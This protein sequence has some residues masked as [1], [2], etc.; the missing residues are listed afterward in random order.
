MTEVKL[1]GSLKPA[2]PTAG[3]LL[4]VCSAVGTECSNWAERDV[5]EKKISSVQI[6]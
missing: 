5:A 3:S 2:L 4:R 1:I 6:R